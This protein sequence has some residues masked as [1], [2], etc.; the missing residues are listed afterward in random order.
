MARYPEIYVL[1]H[2]QTV[3]NIAGRHQGQMDSPLTKKGRLQAYEQGQLLAG[4]DLDWAQTDVF[5][6]PQGRAV[7]TASIALKVVDQDAVEDGRL[8]EVSFG[9]W[10][11]LTLPSIEAGWPHIDH[12]GDPFLWNF[13]APGGE[14]FEGLTERLVGFLEEL[15]RPSV[16]ICHGITSRV[17]RGLWLGLDMQAMG[18]LPG[19]QGCI[20]HLSA[21]GQT[22]MRL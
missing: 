18:D 5:C 13:M 19:G 11:G 21:R 17:L 2:G 16:V 22:E 3:W 1:R 15:R 20:H 10:E 12:A 6:S 8:R 4:L 9:A 14:R 7:E